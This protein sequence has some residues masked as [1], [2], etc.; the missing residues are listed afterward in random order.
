MISQ[1]CVSLDLETTGLDPDTDEI[2]EIGAVKFRGG[3]V[4][5]TFESLVNPQRSVPYRVQLLCGIEQAQVDCAPPFSDLADRLRAFLEGCCIV[6]H[7]VAFDLGFLERKGIVPDGVALDTWELATTLLFEQPNYSLAS[8][9]VTL[10]LTR[11]LHRALSDAMAAKDLFAALYERAAGLDLATIEKVVYLAEKADWPQGAFFRDVLQ[12]R[13]MTAF[14]G[15]GRGPGTTTEATLR[16]GHVEAGSERR[17]GGDRKALDIGDL[18]DMLGP[19]GALARA[20]PDYEYRPGQ[21]EMMQEVARSLN[22]GEHLIVEAGTG[23]GKSL[24]YLLPALL[25]ALDNDVPVVVSTN[26]I[27][28]QEQLVG[29]DI[30]DLI[31][32]LGESPVDG[33]DGL[34][35]AQLKGRSNYLCVRK[36][37]ALSGSSR[38][39]VEE[40]RM[41]ARVTVWLLST[42]TG[43]R[44]E[45]SIGG[46][47]VS[48]WGKICSES[49]E[50][51]EGRCPHRQTDSCFL[52]RARSAAASAHL[53][54][55]NHALLLSDIVADTKILPP[56][57]HLIIDEAHHLENE[58]TEQLGSTVTQ[59]DLLKY[60]G[61][62]RQ[63]TG[64]QRPAGLL[65][66]LNDIFRGRKLAG[67]RQGQLTAIADSLGAHVDR[68]DLRLSQFL[69]RVRSFAKGRA[70]D[71]AGYDRHVLLTPDMRREE[72]WTSVELAWEDLGLV[73][74]DVADGLDR[75]Y[76]SLEDLNERE[77]QDRDH[78]MLELS[79]LYD[80]TLD[81]V[82]R[83]DTFVVHPDSADVH[84][85]V[86]R[87]N[88]GSIE[89]RA[90]P[91]SVSEALDK[92]IFSC[93]DSVV[94]TSATLAIGGTFEYIRGRL[95]MESG[96]ELLVG[97]PF[98]YEASTLICLPHDV[99]APSSPGYQQAFRDALIGL[100]CASRGRAL[101][102]FTSYS[103]L[104][105]TLEVIRAPLEEEGILV[106]GQGVDGSP[107]QL[108]SILKENRATVLLGTSSFWEGI[109]VVG[110]ALSLL[111]IA[112][113]PFNVP[114]DPIFSARSALFDDPFNQYAIPQA[115]IRFKQG[116]GRLIRSKDD[117]GVAVIFDKRLQT[118]HYGSAFLDSIPRCTIARGPARDLPGTVARWLDRGSEG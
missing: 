108:Q 102:L 30:I 82:G 8:L 83:L 89:F 11:P 112:K 76:V 75:L 27:N 1:T 61:R 51:L 74:R 115:A 97:A 46:P 67:S 110:E 68:A 48:V 4:I 26:T 41:L 55:V 104:K 31:A 114:T 80:W 52:Y 64:G 18:T 90:A 98:D 77:T 16:F 20:L 109:D 101:V 69:D 81:L 60:L 43:D 66:W 71:H 86:T 113:L 23:T 28:L 116:F 73:L 7:N 5:D 12:H 45:L 22:D 94:L 96:S 37:E 72:A 57:S 58:A 49:D 17:A 54:V 88:N 62:F 107:K 39:T 105:G 29:K 14:S 25:F 79:W 40:A 38:L 99:P 103:A 6:G 92:S 63:D 47:D 19:G 3:E 15:S 70:S 33:L 36:Y 44:A 50:R 10:G 21:V 84:W 87:G 2:I 100:C 13:A 95:G 106:L 53:I 117:R 9:T 59:W 65:A 91:L 85:L 35:V 93:K 56:Y 78:L 34:R 42:K 24:A 32:A 118:K 111:V